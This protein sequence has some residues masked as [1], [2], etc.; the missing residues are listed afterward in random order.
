MLLDKEVIA[1]WT[2][3]QQV[4]GHHYNSN[5]VVYNSNYLEEKCQR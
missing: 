3:V 2:H 5:D 1:L 4:E